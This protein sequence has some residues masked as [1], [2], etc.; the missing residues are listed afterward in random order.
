M[1]PL[2]AA[3]ALLVLTTPAFASSA[4]EWDCGNGATA[5]SGKGELGFG[6]ILGSMYGEK[7]TYPRRGS[8][9]P[10]WRWDFRGG[11]SK[12]WLNGKRCKQTN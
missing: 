5:T 6:T 4:A 7:G 3:V 8:H 12:V 1:K 2:I 10:D 9:R 11:R